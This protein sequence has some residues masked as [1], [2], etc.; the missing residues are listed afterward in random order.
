VSAEKKNFPDAQID[1]ILEQVKKKRTTEQA[2]RGTAAPGDDSVEAILKGF[3]LGGPRPSY[4]DP[5]LLPDPKREEAPAA[6]DEM[7]ALLGLAPAA[8]AVSEVPTAPEAPPAP[9]RTAQIDVPI[10][11]PVAPVQELSVAAEPIT[12]ELPTIKSFTEAQ[13]QRQ[14]RERKR[15]MEEAVREARN[16]I[17]NSAQFAIQ[18]EVARNLAA[19]QQAEGDVSAE[20]DK[21]STYAGMRFGDVDVDE[22]FQNFFKKTVATDLAA[23]DEVAGRRKGLFTGFFQ[24]LRGQKNGADDT[25]ELTGDFDVILPTAGKAA[26]AAVPVAEA[27]GA[28][29]WS[30]ITLDLPHTKASEG[31]KSAAVLA[32][33]MADAHTEEHVHV[34]KQAP[35]DAAQAAAQPV[36]DTENEYC[37]LGDAP[38]V[39]ANLAAM[40]KTRLLRTGI[41]GAIALVLLYL[42]LSARSGGFPPIT[43]LDPHAAPLAFLL[44]NFILLAAAALL[45]IS[46]M[47][48]GVLGLVR[49]PTTDTFCAVAVLGALVQNVA[50]LFLVED[51]DPERVT[52]FAPVAAVL[53]FGNALGKW[54]Q[55]DV[56]CKNFALITSGEDHAAAFLMPQEQLVKR[57]CS[58]LAE[59]EPHLLISRPTALVRGFLRQSFSVRLNDAMAQNLSYVL[60][61]SA[62]VC[63][64]ICGVKSGSV[65]AAFSGFAAAA[66]LGAPLGSTL[67]YAVPSL[68]L[69]KNAAKDGAMIPGPS[70]VETLGKTNTVLLNAADLFPV[71]SVLLHGIKTFEKERIDIAILYAASLLAPNCETLKDV[72]LNILQGNEKLLYPVEGLTVETGYGMMG[73][74]ENNR[75]LVGNR[76]MMLRHDIEL[77]SLDY[78]NKYTKNGQRAPIYLAVAG[79]LF[80]MFVVSYQPNMGAQDTLDRLGQN[81]ISVLILSDD[82]NVTGPLVSATYGVPAGMVKVLSQPECDALLTQTAY[83]AESD[84]VMIHTGTCASFLGGLRAAACAASGERF[85]R[86]IQATSIFLGAVAGAALALNAGLSGMALGAVLLYQLGWTLFTVAVPLAKKP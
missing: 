30:S 75:V 23:M 63:A 64:V 83:R 58:G 61:G 59:Q 53:L 22:T 62:L 70:A 66:C 72:F 44:V 46:T 50:Y 56:I 17:H 67:V 21:F 18:Q 9:V 11:G 14:E 33:A 34:R 6:P 15:I 29:R 1:D 73:W 45:S 38:V 19:V 60:A 84:G 68:L 42:G 27:Q 26:V 51:F 4:S 35:A 76:A 39:Q 55:M 69:Q 28:A 81:G 7:G 5:I 13:A 43:A 80:G 52:L 20:S 3:G 24:S 40:R 79:K 16:T 25:G 47:G 2:A 85:A 12:V 86:I 57:L 36:Q 82:F 49:E 32:Q 31:K 77:P 65:L 48:A 54:L 71:G 37:A 41:T 74:I 10:D 8:P 78:E